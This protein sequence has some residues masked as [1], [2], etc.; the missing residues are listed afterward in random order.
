MVEVLKRGVPPAERTVDC[1]C[2]NCESELRFFKSEAVE[3]GN[4]QKGVWL[5][6]SCPV[7]GATLEVLE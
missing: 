6:I 4:P 1:L 3:K 7:C 5:E 2:T